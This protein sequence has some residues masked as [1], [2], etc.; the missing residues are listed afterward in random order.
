MISSIPNFIIFKYI[1]EQ[2]LYDLY[3]FV[4][5]CDGLTLN[6]LNDHYGQTMIDNYRNDRYDGQTILLFRIMKMHI[7]VHTCSHTSSCLP[8]TFCPLAFIIKWSRCNRTEA[9]YNC[10]VVILAAFMLENSDNTQ[11][12]LPVWPVIFCFLASAF[13]F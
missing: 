2:K 1:N 6:I 8:T 4:N 13:T 3:F 9:V 11:K 5:L 7:C 12:E 10:L